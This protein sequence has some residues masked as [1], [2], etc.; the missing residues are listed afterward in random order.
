MKYLSFTIDWNM[1]GSWLQL[2]DRNEILKLEKIARKVID[3]TT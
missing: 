1:E 3:A 2:F